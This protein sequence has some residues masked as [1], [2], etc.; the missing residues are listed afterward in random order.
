MLYRLATLIVVLLWAQPVHAQSRFFELANTALSIIRGISDLLFGVAASIAV[1]MVVIGGLYYMQHPDAG[2]K[3]ILA[4]LIGLAIVAFT[5]VI[6][7]RA[8]FVG[9]Q[10]Q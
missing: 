6:L 3:I 7:E 9:Q 5:W 1:L 2:K 8:T 10:F 4:S